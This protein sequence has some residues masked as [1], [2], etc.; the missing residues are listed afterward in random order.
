MNV[1]GGGL[2]FELSHDG[3]QF[4]GSKGGNNGTAG[5]KNVQAVDDTETT[6]TTMNWYVDEQT[7][8]TRYSLL[9]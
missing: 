7:G 9:A 8:R 2:S 5:G 1:A 4:Q 3:S 6:E